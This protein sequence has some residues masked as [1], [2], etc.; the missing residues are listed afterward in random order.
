MNHSQ[1]LVLFLLTVQSFS[2][3]GYK[4]YNQS[5]FGVD[6]PVMSMCSCPSPVLLEEGVCYDHCILLAEF[7]QPLPSFI[8]YSKAKLA[9]YSKCLLTSYFSI[10]V[11]Y[12]EKDIF[13]GVSSRKSCRYSQNRS[14]SASLA[15]V[16]GT[17][18]CITVILNRLLWKQTEIILSFLRLHPGTAF[19]TLLL[20]MRATPFLLR[21]SCP[22][23]QI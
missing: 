23:Q 9:C 18:T 21:D 12:D 10:P 14:T 20:T 4:E 17:Q 3:F 6:H 15:L 16:G 22:Q 8:L 7:Y 2:I 11:P 19:Q 5:D 13:F 1:L